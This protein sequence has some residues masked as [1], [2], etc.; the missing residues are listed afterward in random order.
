MFGYSSYRTVLRHTWQDC[1]SQRREK[2]LSSS[3]A[4]VLLNEVI[5][6]A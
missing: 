1:Y 6:T 4:E 5:Y 2:S 3:F